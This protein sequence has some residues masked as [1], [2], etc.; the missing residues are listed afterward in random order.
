MN[1]QPSKSPTVSII[2]LTYNNLDYTR[3]CLESIYAQA[4]PAQPDFELIV[5]DNA[6]QDDTPDYLRTFASEHPSMH[7]IFNTEN[8]GFA[9]GNNIGAQAACGDYVIF[10]NNDTIVTQ[11]WIAGLLAHLQDHEVGM[12]GPVTNASGNETRIPV[13]Y[14]NIE[15]M[16]A[17]AAQYIQ[18]H[19]GQ[20][21]EIAML[22]F[23]CAA[24]RRAV[25]EEIGPLDEHFGRGMFEDDDYALRLR[26][27]GYRI[28]CAEDAFIHHWGSASFS[29]LGMEEYWKLFRENLEYF[30][31][32]WNIQWRPSVLR[33]ELL[34]Q[35]MRQFVDG[36]IWQADAIAQLKDSI[37][38][39]DQFIETQWGYVLDRDQKI[40]QLAER[41]TY[42]T[43]E[44][45]RLTS[46]LDSI[47]FSRAWRLVQFLWRL[48][49]FLLPRYSRRERWAKAILRPVII[50]R[51]EGSA[52]LW[53]HLLGW[54]LSRSWVRKIFNGMIS[55]APTRTRIFI[56]NFR[57]ETHFVDRSEVILFA[58]EDILPNYKNR[59]PIEDCTAAED[60]KPPT[61]KISLIATV[62]NESPNAHLWLE[63]LARQSRLPDEIIVTD[64]GSTD[65]TITILRNFSETSSIPIKVFE[66]P[67][68]NIARGRNI[69]IQH[70][71]YPIIACTDFG[72]VLDPDWLYY[73][74]L[75]FELDE[76]IDIS[77]GYYKSISDNALQ[78]IYA[79]FF[80]E[81]V[82]KIDPQ[83]FLPSSR[84]IAFKKDLWEK[85][86]GYPEWLTY[87]GED[88]LFDLQ[89]KSQSSYWAFSP[90][91]LVSWH[92]PSAIR[93]IYKT[94]WRYARGDGEAGIFSS[95]YRYKIELFLRLPIAVFLILVVGMASAYFSI[96]YTTKWPPILFD[97]FILFL[98][99]LEVYK[100]YSA[101][102]KL[103]I[104]FR[105]AVAHKLIWETINFAQ[106]SGFWNGVDNR[107]N[108]HARRDA[109]YRQQLK[110]IIA[111]HTDAQGI[112][113]Y[114]PTHDWGF[115]F[116]RPH[117]IGRACA[118]QK[119]LYFFGTN[120]EK[121]DAV[122]GFRQAEPYLY[123]YHLP[124]E[125]FNEIEHPI[126]YIGAAWHHN[127]LSVFNKPT[128]IYDHY[129]DLEVSS[130]RIEDHYA[131]L[132][133]ADIVVVTSQK[134]LEAVKTERPDALYAPNGV[135]Y[136]FIQQNLPQPE[137]PVPDDWPPIAK[138][139]KS[140][141]GYSGA[142]AEWFDYE[143]LA[144][145][146][147]ARPDLEFVLLGVN[148]DGSLDR[149]GVLALENIHWL[150][151]K[152]Y[153][154]LFKYISR[155]NVATIPF[156]VYSITIATS[157]VKLFEYA[158][159]QKPII[160]TD[161]PEC[162]RYSSVLI[163]K[164]Q[165]QF[166]THIDQALQLSHDSAY[167][168]SLQLLAQE[169]TWDNRVQTILQ[170]LKHPA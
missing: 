110:E 64:G 120:N 39:R 75:P 100:I 34:G 1:D 142:L 42:L 4:D 99:L 83:S 77:V 37:A 73:L 151:M 168:A 19:R 14:Q 85:A 111:A 17:F 44:T 68:A 60:R 160:S 52:G 157:P 149:S 115:M 43:G 94:T 62:R 15:D 74:A 90:H 109:S 137:E 114:P 82:Q 59:H 28:L 9:G 12:V 116:Q 135:D 128:I 88:T 5:V 95:N 50:L 165:E 130:A 147:Q 63:S 96:H 125:I 8:W 36:L 29:R 119:Y 51:R 66:T 11:G 7:P 136:S 134:L 56:Q 166:L 20:S 67:G 41:I 112:I 144:F 139:G 54:L 24:L 84:S 108:V 159:C 132:K 103:G 61:V 70:A 6:S 127:L 161:L 106:M 81:D 155:F 153:H 38:T 18:A 156:R 31:N 89:M 10:L 27:K 92:S 150:G 145:A 146:A 25:F 126:V 121:S 124:V 69:A 71:Q 58:Q 79:R 169:N 98:L 102:R 97:C 40:N 55:H 48:R 148:Y 133:E 162:R 80:V 87:A 164:D 35:Q 32:K 26:Q 140:V 170:K 113:I 78:H 3:Q 65:D 107:P 163:A 22:P 104:S 30:E 152:P 123:L 105:L 122:F 138:S 131:L 101:S 57:Q 21:F 158:A 45:N 33:S 2:V 53:H 143:L 13:S 86:G 16:P 154:E 118:R 72:C 47:K 49:L 46:E 129:D 91:A 117:Q 141:I 93:N 76:Q 23:Q 167:L